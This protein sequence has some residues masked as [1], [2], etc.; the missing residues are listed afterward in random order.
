MKPKK[1]GT[2][3]P[4]PLSM[5]L[6]SQTKPGAVTRNRTPDLSLTTGVLY[7]L[8]YD[9]KCIWL[10]E[11]DLNHQP[12]SY[13]HAAL[14]IELSRAI[15]W[16]DWKGWPVFPSGYGL[17]QRFPAASARRPNPTT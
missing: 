11:M 14:P 8:S 4:N 17:P 12:A 7:Q 1:K 9:G 10:R 13:E 2:G 16:L 5:A 6:T 3:Y 15:R